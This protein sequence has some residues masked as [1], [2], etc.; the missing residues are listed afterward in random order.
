MAERFS[1]T[2]VSALPPVM[3]AGTCP[4]AMPVPLCIASHHTGRRLCLLS[5]ITQPRQLSV[6]RRLEHDCSSN[7]SPV[8]VRHQWQAAIVLG[9]TAEP[10]Q[11]AHLGPPHTIHS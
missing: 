2:Y 1:H 4:C 10:H 8:S 11:G 6:A 7:A 3:Q 9:L 5:A